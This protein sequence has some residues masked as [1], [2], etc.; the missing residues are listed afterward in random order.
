MIDERSSTFWE[1]AIVAGVQPN[2]F[3]V[4]H[5][6]SC[7]I[8]M[9]VHFLE[10]SIYAM[11]FLLETMTWSSVTLLISLLLLTGVFGLIFGAY[12]SVKFDNA[13]TALNICSGFAF[14]SFYLSGKVSFVQIH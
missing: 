2:H 9:L 8:V 10:Y 1:R 5:L 4:S 3:L 13:I 6:L 14:L 12:L 7:F 11:F